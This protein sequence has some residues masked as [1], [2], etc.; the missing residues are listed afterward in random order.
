MRCYHVTRKRR[1][2]CAIEWAI[3]RHVVARAEETHN[4]DDHGDDDD[5]GENGNVR[6]SKESKMKLETH[7]E[8]RTIAVRWAWSLILHSQ[9]IIV[10]TIYIF[11]I[12]FFFLLNSPF[13]M[14]LVS[15]PSIVQCA[16]DDNLNDHTCSLIMKM[17]V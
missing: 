3:E 6:T 11:L 15:A 12:H 5:D 7:D 1:K 13:K 17:K 4:S 2:V 10:N 8:H 14:Q 9:S 16:N